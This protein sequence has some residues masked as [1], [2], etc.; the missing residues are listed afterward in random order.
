MILKEAKSMCASCNFIISISLICQEIRP[1]WIL[2]AKESDW[3]YRD[4]PRR[5]LGLGII[6]VTVW[7]TNCLK[8]LDAPMSA[9]N[10]INICDYLEAMIFLV[11]WFCSE[12][13][14]WDSANV[15]NI[16]WFNVFPE[17]AA[18]IQ[19]LSFDS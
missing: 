10:Y 17:P 16:I 5:A 2:P 9:L 7:Q 8:I 15:K 6:I 13:L 14:S 18:I 3:P 4:A 19:S 1:S 12:N 11:P